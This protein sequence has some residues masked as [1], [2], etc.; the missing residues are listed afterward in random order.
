MSAG[1]ERE[2]MVHLVPGDDNQSAVGEFIETGAK[3][4][5]EETARKRDT[6]A[7]GI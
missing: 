4:I 6:R 3:E 2:K 7:S 5:V 1:R